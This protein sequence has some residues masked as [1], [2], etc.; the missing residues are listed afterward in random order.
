MAFFLKRMDLSHLEQVMLIEEKLFSSP[1]NFPMFISEIENYDS[2][3]LLNKEN[4]ILGYLCGRSVL[5]EFS[6]TNIGIEQKSQRQGLGSIL[7]EEIILKMKTL[8]IKDFFLEVRESNIAAIKLYQN[9]N[10]VRLGKRKKYY[11]SPIE[12]AILMGLIT[13]K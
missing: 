8:G 2:F 13:S 11:S 12:D 6:I 10:F 1:W 9:F 7:L 4:Q 3:V 5:D